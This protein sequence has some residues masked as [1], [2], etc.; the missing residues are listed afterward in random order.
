M[1]VKDSQLPKPGLLLQQHSNNTL[2]QEATATCDQVDQCWHLCRFCH[3]QLWEENT[4]CFNDV[5]LLEGSSRWDDNLGGRGLVA[6]AAAVC[7]QPSDCP[8]SYPS[9]SDWMQNGLGI[10]VDGKNDWGY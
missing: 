5:F 7:W 8:P 10:E 2:P 4:T 3:A 6:V 1:Q 9:H